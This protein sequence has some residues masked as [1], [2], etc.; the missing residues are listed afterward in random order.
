MGVGT[1]WDYLGLPLAVPTNEVNSLP[2]RA[3]NLIWN[4]YYRNQEFQA[5]LPYKDVEADK[6]C[7]KV[8]KTN[9]GNDFFTTA[10]PD[11]QRG[12]PP[13]LPVQGK[14]SFLGDF[15]DQTQQGRQA[16]LA[17]DNTTNSIL[18]VGSDWGLVDGLD[19]WLAN[20]ELSATTF[21]MNDMY[22]AQAV[23]SFQVLSQF[24]GYLYPDYLQANYGTKPENST[25]QIPEHIGGDKSPLRISEVLQTSQT[26]ADSPQGNLAG[27]G[28]GTSA[29]ST[30]SYRCQDFGYIIGLVV[31][32]PVALY[33]QRIDKKWTKKSSLDFFN[34]LFGNLPAQPILNQEI[35]ASDDPNENLRIWAYQPAWQELRTNVSYVTNELRPSSNLNYW[36]IARSF[37]KLPALNSNFLETDLTDRIFAVD[38][39][40]ASPFIMEMGIQISATRPIPQ[41]SIPAF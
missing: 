29:R 41:Y 33:D 40:K 19:K 2:I 5:E 38:K 17:Y 18:A 35:Y 7:E 11:I 31:V 21:T 12:T 34:P 3:Y 14:T 13:A 22:F 20:N 32:Q 1:L 36:S 9:W 28:L 26:T 25:L 15:R 10:K 4:W 24:T 30:N 39:D 27:H 16:N 6:L 37:D 8:L 23:N